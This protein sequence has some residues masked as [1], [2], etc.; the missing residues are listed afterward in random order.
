MATLQYSVIHLKQQQLSQSAE[1]V[2]ILPPSFYSLLHT[3]KKEKKRPHYTLEN[4]F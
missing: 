4:I 2:Y 3:G 1:A